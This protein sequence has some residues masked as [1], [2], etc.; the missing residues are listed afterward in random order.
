MPRAS[1]LTSV[2]LDVGEEPR[3]LSRPEPDGPFRIL[4]AGDF[5]AGASRIRKPVQVDRDNFEDVLELYKPEI[6]LVGG[7][8][9]V[10]ISFREMEDF[11]PDSLFER[12]PLFRSLRDLRQQ[13]KDGMVAFPK[14]EPKASGASL[15][16]DM[17]GESAAVAPAPTRN[18]WDSM[19]E[20]IVA[21]H[22]E[23][24]QDPRQAGMI[25]QTDD[26]VTTG[27]RALLHCR[28]FQELEA[29]WCAL[30]F[31]VRRLETSTDLKVYVWDMPQSDLVGPDG[32]AALRRVMV[33]E[34]VGTP[35]ADRWSVIAGLYYF[36]NEHESA[37]SQIAAM[38]RAAGAPFLSGVAKDS[39]VSGQLF[40]TL[41]QTPDARWLGLAM[42]RFL[43]RLPYGEKTGST[44]RFRFEEMPEVP[45]HESY[46]WGHPAVVCAYLLGEAFSRSGWDM[47]PGEV[48]QVEGL[49]AHVYQ[50]D[51]E[52]ELKPCAEVLLTESTAELLMELGLMPLLSLK[53]SDR[54]RLARFQSL[55]H[56][57][58]AL[59][60][61]W[62]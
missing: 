7:D 8:S 11:H 17:L 60:G 10:A 3:E 39:V 23:P 12:L 46:L 30:F 36:G 20:D 40:P 47:R 24:K 1:S 26:A 38:S 18:A 54:V 9:P 2:H 55:A 52:P 59:N 57:V 49:P 37:L 61:P 45:E 43:L 27:M 58:A 13:L 28:P 62:Q 51:G 22:I 15:L 56:P 35:G 21:P 50:K 32:L 53:G 48:S 25:S 4:L 41:R 33:E 34:T 6:R 44:E 16:A 19:I 31:L 14:L 29:L 5:S 42:P